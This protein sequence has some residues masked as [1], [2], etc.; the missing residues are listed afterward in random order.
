MSN[1]VSLVVQQLGV[2]VERTSLK[3]RYADQHPLVRTA[4]IN[5]ESISQEAL[6]GFPGVSSL[7]YAL[8]MLCWAG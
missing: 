3:E 4:D 8:H 1:E 7:A 5:L 2:G 6:P